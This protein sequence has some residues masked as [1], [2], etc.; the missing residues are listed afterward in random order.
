MRVGRLL[1]VLLGLLGAGSAP[2]PAAAEPPK[3]STASSPPGEAAAFRSF[4]DGLWPEA[5]AA[6]VP[7]ATFDAAF[8]DLTAPDPKIVAQTKSQSE[9]SRPISE[10]VAGAASPDRVAKGRALS[11]RWSSVLDNIERRYRVQR[12][13]ALAIWG[14]ESGFG[15]ASGGFPVVRALAT[16]AFV[17]Q[18]QDVF[19]RELIDAL[20]IMQGEHLEA[21]ALTG[22]WAGAMGQ[23]QF[24]PSSFLAHA[25]DG[26]GDGR[27]DIWNS[28]PD[29]LASIANFIAQSGW[30]AGLPWGFEIVLPAG[31][32]LSLH[33][34]ALADWGRLGVR[35]ADGKPLPPAGEASLFLPAGVKGPAFLLTDNFEAI[36]AYNTSDSYALGVGLLADR[37]AGAGPLTR[38]WPKE[39]VLSGEE[40]REVHRRLAALGLYAGA[41]DGK[42]GAQT[43]DAVRRFQIAAGLVPDGYADV[44]LLE[45]LRKR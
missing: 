4:L 7:R 5:A 45:A 32:D 31:M 21:A 27:R 42:F 10:Y 22:S 37:I 41:Q 12:D 29:V 34:R 16:L 15:A 19:R 44:S 18:R 3:P 40:R 2:W 24:M 6:G 14:L 9:F 1:A 26:D 43:R 39:R 33:R 30:Q 17:G 23:T 35:R 28:T 20:R 36:R 8:R 13:I 25:V 38:A 11:T